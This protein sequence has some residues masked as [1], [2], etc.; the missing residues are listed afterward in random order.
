MTDLD[1]TVLHETNG[2]VSIPDQVA[3]GLTALAAHGR[4]II[5]NT[6]RFPANVIRSF[7]PKWHAIQGGAVPLI[8]LNGAI[9]GM[10]VMTASG[11][12]GFDELFAQPLTPQEI[13]AVL[14]ELEAEI[15]A[16]AQ[17]VVLFFHPR[18]WRLGETLWTPDERRIPALHQKY[19]NADRV[20]AVELSALREELFCR[21]ICLLLIPHGETPIHRQQQRRFFHTGGNANK[22]SGARRMADALGIELEASIGAGD[23]MMDV[24]LTGTGLAIRVGAPDLTYEGLAGAIDVADPAGFGATMLTLAALLDMQ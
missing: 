1:G 11:A 12:M 20:I 2:R 8:S 22:L 23:T 3:A 19:P 24:F 13:D 6:L 9:G 18:D 4:P 17:D 15:V 16:G 21:D 7:G 5:L 10:I 14:S